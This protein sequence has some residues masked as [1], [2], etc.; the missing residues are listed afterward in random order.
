MVRDTVS[1]PEFGVVAALKRG[2]FWGAILLPL[3]YLPML[4]TGLDS[5]F[6]HLL[7]VSLLALNVVLLVVGHTHR[8]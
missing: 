2:A 8:T 4:V 6:Q 3:V 7:F 5:V 1:V